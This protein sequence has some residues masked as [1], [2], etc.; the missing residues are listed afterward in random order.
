MAVRPATRCLQ[1]LDD[2]LLHDRRQ[3]IGVQFIR[4][5]ADDRVVC[6]GPSIHDRDS[7]G[8]HISLTRYKRLNLLIVAILHGLGDWFSYALALVARVSSVVDCVPI[9][10]R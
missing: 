7:K 2:R 1:R 10:V 9:R 6:S 5:R 4:G 8:R 3:S